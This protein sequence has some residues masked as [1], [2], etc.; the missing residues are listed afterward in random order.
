MLGT[1][2]DRMH[3]FVFFYKR[4]LSQQAIDAADH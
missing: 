3:Y 4:L 1:G 2:L